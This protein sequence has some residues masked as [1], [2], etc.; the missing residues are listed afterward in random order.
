MI[1]MLGIGIGILLLVAAHVLK[2]Q[3]PLATTGNESTARS[4]QAR[5][6]KVLGWVVLFVSIAVPFGLVLFWSVF[7]PDRSF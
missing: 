1:V 6:L 3:S 5:V 4:M 7:A 2:R